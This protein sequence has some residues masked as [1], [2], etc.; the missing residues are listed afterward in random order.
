MPGLL[1]IKMHLKHLQKILNFWKESKILLSMHVKLICQI[2]QPSLPL[3]KLLKEILN[4]EVG[5]LN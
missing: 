5:Y 3:N 4:E 1:D 2:N